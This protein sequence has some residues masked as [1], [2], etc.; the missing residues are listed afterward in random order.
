[1]KI[2]V[3]A[4]H[5]APEAPNVYVVGDSASSNH[6]PSAQSA[7]QQGEQVADVLQADLNAKEPKQP[8]EIK[9]KGTLGS[10]GKSD[11]FENMFQQPL[12]GLLP[13]LAKSGVFWLHKRH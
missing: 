6:S 10:L 12:T 11:G 2:K 5:Q 13:R 4:Y 3:N 8:K 1:G 7:K 9:F